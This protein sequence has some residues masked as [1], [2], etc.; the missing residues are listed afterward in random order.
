[1]KSV[2][3]KVEKS[4][5]GDLSV[6]SDLKSQM[7]NKERASKGK[8]DRQRPRTLNKRRNGEGSKPGPA[9]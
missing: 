3:E 9:R 4:T 6:L 5:L 8:R 2:N 7:E 1:V